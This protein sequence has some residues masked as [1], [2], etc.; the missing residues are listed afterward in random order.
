[1]IGA[2]VGRKLYRR[3]AQ[4]WPQLDDVTMSRL[5]KRAADGT[6]GMRAA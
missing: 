5:G 6:L 3:A 2:L 4:L 1:M